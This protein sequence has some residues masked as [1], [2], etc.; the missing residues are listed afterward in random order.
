MPG[1]WRLGG[2]L[3]SSVSALVD[4]QLDEE[5]TERAWDHVLH[6]PPCRRLVEHEGWVKRQ[7]AQIAGATTPEQPSDR[8]VG[9]LRGLDPAVLDASDAW[10]ATDR[11]E[12]RSRTR[13]R[14]G[15]ALVGAGSVSAA[16]LGLS[17]LTATPMGLAPPTPPRRPRRSSRPPPRC[18]DGCA[19]GPSARVTTASRMRA[20]RETRARGAALEPAA[21]SSR[22]TPYLDGCTQA[23]F[24]GLARG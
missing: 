15:I 10:A 7:L 5:T 2:H 16:V 8:L 18:T 9:S 23:P 21:A 11:L 17:T 24:S 12:D 14:A 20:S 1:M 13:R 22:D 19:A 6:C 4:G 3:G